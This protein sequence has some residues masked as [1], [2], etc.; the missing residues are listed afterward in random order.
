MAAAKLS[1]DRTVD[2]EFRCTGGM[3]WLLMV[4]LGFADPGSTDPLLGAPRSEPVR[5]LVRDMEF[6][7]LNFSFSF[8]IRSET[9]A[10]FAETSTGLG[11]NQALIA[12]EI[13]FQ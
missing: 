1:V 2:A 6:C 11:K 4:G 13:N 8:S 12:C 7:W 10:S 5:E 3:G 9:C